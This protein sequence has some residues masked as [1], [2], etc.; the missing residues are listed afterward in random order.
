MELPDAEYYVFCMRQVHSV[1][2][3]ACAMFA[4]MVIQWNYQTQNLWFCISGL[5]P[6]DLDVGGNGTKY[7]RI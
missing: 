1:H 4:F 2:L 3:D 7:V 5:S 6:L